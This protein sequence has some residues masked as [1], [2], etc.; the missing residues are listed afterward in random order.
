MTITL[1]SWILPLAVTFLAF[2]A[3][4]AL[5]P[6]AKPSGYFPDFGPA[7]IGALLM[8]L[9]VVVSLSAWLL[10]ALVL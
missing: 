2:A 6:A 7:I 9:A 3:S 1:G 4:Y 5:T 8:L 10:W